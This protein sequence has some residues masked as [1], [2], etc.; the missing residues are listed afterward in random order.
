M[1]KTY[2]QKQKKI[3]SIIEKN[4][5]KDIIEKIE[6]GLFIAKM[7]DNYS[8]TLSEEKFIAKEYNPKIGKYGLI[9]K[10]GYL[11]LV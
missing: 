10:G 8:I 1:N 5:L 7:S 3:K 2:K 11:T 4:N 9:I 6:E